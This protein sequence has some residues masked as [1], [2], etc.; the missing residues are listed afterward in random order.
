MSKNK[1][2]SRKKLLA[3]SVIIL[4]A[5]IIAACLLSGVV[6]K[7]LY[8]LKYS[9][10][11]DKYSEQYG[12]PKDLLYA[13]VSVES[14]FD[15]NARSEVGAVGLTQIMPDTLLWLTSKTGESYTEEDLTNPEVS[16][17]Y[18]ALLY[19]ILL[20]KYG[21]RNEAVCAYHAGINQVAVWLKNSEYSSDGKTLDKIPSAKTQH[22]LNKVIKTINIYNNLYEKEFENE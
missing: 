2:K 13:T 11:I 12:V 15:E 22:Y 19:S 14:G 7:Q 16:I 9:E 18:C 10:Y 6:K 20:E 5:V 4:T 3:F 17:K 21:T 1:P 8:P